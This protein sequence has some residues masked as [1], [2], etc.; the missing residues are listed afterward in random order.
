MYAINYFA[1]IQLIY[2]PLL[3]FLSSRA[4]LQRMALQSL[5][6]RITL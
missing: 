5:T 6:L 1:E 3:P 4:Q 2:I